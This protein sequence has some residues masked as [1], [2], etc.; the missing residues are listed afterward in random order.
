VPGAIDDFRSFIASDMPDGYAVTIT[1][2]E[3]TESPPSLTVT[4][5][6]TFSTLFKQYG[7]DDLTM[8][9]TVKATNY[10]VI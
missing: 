2:I 4:G 6:I 9:F 10:R 7:F 1:S 5:T 3:G 8:D